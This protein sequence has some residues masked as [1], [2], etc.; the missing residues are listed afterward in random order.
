MSAHTAIIAMLKG[1]IAIAVFPAMLF[2]FVIVGV[3]L[4]QVIGEIAAIKVLVGVMIVMRKKFGQL[5]NLFCK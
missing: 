2:F 5:H 4:N 3:M 1:Q